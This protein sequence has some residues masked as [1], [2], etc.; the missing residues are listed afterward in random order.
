MGG[1]AATGKEYVGVIA[2]DIQPIAPYMIETVKKKLRETDAG[3]EDLLMY[4]GTALTYILVNAVKEQQKQ[5]EDLTSKLNSQGREFSK[6]LSGL[7]A[8]IELL[9]SNP[10]KQVSTTN[11]VK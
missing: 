2:Q 5:I 9:K 11:G 10:D 3:T 6:N 4:D 8:E 1:Y 7:K